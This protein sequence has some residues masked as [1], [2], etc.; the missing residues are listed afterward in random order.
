MFEAQE[1]NIPRNLTEAGQLSLRYLNYPGKRILLPARKAIENGVLSFDGSNFRYG[2]TLFTPDKQWNMVGPTFFSLDEAFVKAEKGGLYR[3]QLT[4]A[5]REYTELQEAGMDHLYGNFVIFPHREHIVQYPS[6]DLYRFALVASSSTLLL[7]PKRIMTWEQVREVFDNMV[8]PVAGASVGSSIF[9]T[10]HMDTR[11]LN[12]KIG[13]PK[14]VKVTNLN[15]FIGSYD[16]VAY[17][18]ALQSLSVYP[19]GLKNKAIS[20][21][22]QMHGNN[23][24]VNI[25]AYFD[26]LTEFNIGSFVKGNE[27]EPK[28]TFVVD[29]MDDP[30]MK[31]MLAETARRHRIRLIRF[32]DAGSAYQCDI[33]PFDLDPNATL[34]YGS[35]DE[36]LYESLRIFQTNPSRDHFFRFADALIG[37]YHRLKPGEFRDLVNGLRPKITGSVEQLGGDATSA[38]GQAADIVAR[39]ALGYKYPERFYF[40]KRGLIV[41]K[42]GKRV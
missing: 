11:N 8:V 40:D 24:F 12:A 18:K 10:I 42:W 36:E 32:T 4:S 3:D 25:Y 5:V 7:D 33:R 39:M 1:N 6:A 20:T 17:P 31:L 15:R 22:E 14:P 13:D 38:A 30:E 2:D 26:G 9:R 41:K 16:Y 27:V 19:S 23:P 37:P 35:T 34:A 28:A 21:A 29:E